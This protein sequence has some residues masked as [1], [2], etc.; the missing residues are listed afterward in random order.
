MTQMV[1]EISKELQCDQEMQRLHRHPDR[2]LSTRL[3]LDIWCLKD[4]RVSEDWTVAGR[5]FHRCDVM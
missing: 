1:R 4:F 2:I 5:V 3:S